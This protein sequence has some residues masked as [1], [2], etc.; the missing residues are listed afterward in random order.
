MLIRTY[1]CQMETN[2]IR[3]VKPNLERAFEYFDKFL[4][5][6][7]G[8]TDGTVEWL[9][10]QPKVDLIRFKWCDDFPKSR[11]Q[12]LKRLEEIRMPDEISIVCVAD[13]DEFYSESLMKNI[14]AL[15]EQMITNGY[16][17]LTVRCRSATLD[18]NW[19]RVSESLDDFWKP[20]IFIWEPGMHYEDPGHV[21][22]ET[23]IV[24]SGV[25]SIRVHDFAGT[26]QE[27]LYEHIKQ[28]GINWVRG[29]RN[30]YTCGGGHN[31]KDKQPLWRPFRELISKHVQFDTWADVENYFSKGNIAQEIKDWFIQHRLDGLPSYDSKYTEIRE[32]FLTYFIWFRPEELPAELIEQDK[33]YM[34]YVAEIER[35]HGKEKCPKTI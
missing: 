35:I 26:E 17:Q 30:F 1:Y 13:D 6:D 34:D 21:V 33:D 25:H 12:Y 29:L 32:G 22:H 19:K 8:S 15:A 5:V 20:L 2:R 23:L 16:N 31:L 10:K 28:E 14:R 18:R 11:N 27:M 24:P 3:T 7:G 4:I 9:E